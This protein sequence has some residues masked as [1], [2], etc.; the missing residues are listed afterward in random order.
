MFA[1][2][3]QEEIVRR[4]HDHPVREIVRR[5]VDELLRQVGQLDGSVDYTQDFC[6]P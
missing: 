6:D 5:F 4:P 3:R 2:E 1:T